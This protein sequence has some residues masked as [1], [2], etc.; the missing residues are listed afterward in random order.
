MCS[1]AFCPGLQRCWALLAPAQNS[2]V[3]TASFLKCE[4]PISLLSVPL[5]LGA[6]GACST[7]TPRCAELTP[8]GQPLPS[9][10]RGNR[11][12]SPASYPSGGWFWGTACV[13]F[14]DPGKPE[15]LMP[16]A[17]TRIMHPNVDFFL[18]C[19]IVLSPTCLLF[20]SSL[21]KAM[22]TYVLISVSAFKE[23]QAKICSICF[24]CYPEAD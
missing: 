1:L 19:L 6:I 11:G 14:E 12:N 23:T 16:T 4:L 13:L 15:L 10:V 20:G 24:P 7:Q 5:N 18:S 22:W 9:G 3:L 2:P 21:R 8:Q 17:A